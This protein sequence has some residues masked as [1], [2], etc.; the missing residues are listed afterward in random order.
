MPLVLMQV[1]FLTK[2]VCHRNNEELWDEITI[3]HN[4]YI[5]IYLIFIWCVHRLPWYHIDCF[6]YIKIFTLSNIYK[7]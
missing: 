2:T 1:C 4:K 3:C 5:I 6:I 7:Y